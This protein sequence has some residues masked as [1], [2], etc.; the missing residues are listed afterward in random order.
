MGSR[1]LLPSYERLAADHGEGLLAYEL[2]RMTGAGDVINRK[3]DEYAKKKYRSGFTM[4]RRWS[5][6]AVDGRDQAPSER[7]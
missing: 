4:I 7:A 3:L 2:P 1:R 5:L 6:A